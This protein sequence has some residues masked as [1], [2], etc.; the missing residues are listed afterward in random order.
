YFHLLKFYLLFVI[1]FVFIWSLKE[2]KKTSMDQMI[3]NGIIINMLLYGLSFQFAPLLR[4]EFYFKIFEFIFLVYYIKDIKYHS[5]ILLKTVVIS[6]FLVVYTG[7]F[8]TDPFNITRYEFRPLRITETKT[9][10]ELFYEINT[11]Y[12]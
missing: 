8:L 9:D 1:I 5:L 4:V 7:L 3:L 12:D 10:E 2:Y 6:F 11:F